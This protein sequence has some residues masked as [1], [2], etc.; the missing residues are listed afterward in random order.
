MLP[1]K[2]TIRRSLGLLVITVSAILLLAQVGLIFPSDQF[3]FAQERETIVS[4]SL[5]GLIIGAYLVAGPLGAM[6]T[7]LPLASSGCVGCGGAG[8]AEEEEEEDLGKP[9]DPPPDSL[10]SRFSFFQWR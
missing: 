10:S 1:T 7:F 2:L 8:R 4:I 5:G 9:P 6:I 3:P